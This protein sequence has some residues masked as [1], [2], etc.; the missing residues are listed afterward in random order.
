MVV[1]ANHYREAEATPKAEIENN[2]STDQMPMSEEARYL[3]DTT[4]PEGEGYHKLGR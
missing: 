3:E 1:R 4:N 2:M